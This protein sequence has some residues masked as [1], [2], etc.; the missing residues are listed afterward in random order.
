VMLRWHLQ[1]GRSTIP[2]STRPRRI[3]E[4]IDIFDFELNDEE[5][6]GS[7]PAGAAD[8]NRAT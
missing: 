1:Q 2:R 5:S 8:R 7:I 3:A 6:T 4:N